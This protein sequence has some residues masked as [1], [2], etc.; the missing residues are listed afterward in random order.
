MTLMHVKMINIL[1]LTTYMLTKQSTNTSQ[2]LMHVQAQW[3]Y[4]KFHRSHTQT[5]M[6]VD[7]AQLSRKYKNPIGM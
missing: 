4:K 2:S 6:H 1:K 3:N 7:N 5:L